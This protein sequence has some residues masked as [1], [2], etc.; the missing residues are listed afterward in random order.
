M[1][2]KRKKPVGKPLPPRIYTPGKI[3]AKYTATKKPPRFTN[4]TAPATVAL[5]CYA[6]AYA[7]VV[8]LTNTYNNVKLPFNSRA[9][10]AGLLVAAEAKLAYWARATN[11]NTTV[12]ANRAAAL[13]KA[14]SNNYYNL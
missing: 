14:L 5:T 9:I 12:A 1:A 7:N 6:K 11:L 4:Y 8:I 13:K 10:A 2:Y 3:P